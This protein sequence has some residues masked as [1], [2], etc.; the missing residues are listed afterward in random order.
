MHRSSGKRK[1]TTILLKESRR[2]R[3]PPLLRVPEIFTKVLLCVFAAVATLTDR[4]ANSP[5]K[6][7]FD[8]ETYYFTLHIC[9]IHKLDFRINAN[10]L[11][12]L[13]TIKHEIQV[14][15]IP[16]KYMEI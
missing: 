12:D 10:K 7:S 13:A 4:W 9:K 5:F 1:K 15:D 11:E 6:K 14:S 2:E 16:Y 8:Q 3:R